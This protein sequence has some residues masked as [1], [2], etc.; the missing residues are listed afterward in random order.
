MR[1]LLYSVFNINLGMQLYHED[2]QNEIG[3]RIVIL[4]NAVGIVFF[5]SG[6][7]TNWY[8]NGDFIQVII[9]GMFWSAIMLSGFLFFGYIAY[10]ITESFKGKT[11]FFDIFILFS[12]AITPLL[13][14][15]IV[16]RVIYLSKAIPF[17]YETNAGFILYGLGILVSLKIL[18]FGIK[19]LSGITTYQAVICI[20]PYCVGKT[21]YIIHL[22]YNKSYL[23]ILSDY[24]FQHL[25]FYSR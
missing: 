24:N 5:L 14:L 6:L 3:T 20:I 21:V 18:V 16:F 19:K 9:S 15:H 23:D 1:S 4:L 11:S 8:D 17:L 22:L 2:L 10:K 12:Y 7:Y 13:L 25:I